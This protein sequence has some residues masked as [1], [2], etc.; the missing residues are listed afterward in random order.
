MTISIRA[1]DPREVDRL[2]GPIAQANTE[3][4]WQQYD[5]SEQ[6]AVAY[7]ADMALSIDGR[8]KFGQSLAE[9]G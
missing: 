5:I 8:A 9:A 3:L 2:G 7:V 6:Y 1:Y 4:R